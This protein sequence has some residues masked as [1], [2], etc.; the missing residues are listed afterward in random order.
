MLCIVIFKSRGWPKVMYMFPSLFVILTLCIKKLIYVYLT[1]WGLGSGG[2]GGGGTG[3][4]T[5]LYR[6]YR[7][8][9]CQ[10]V[11]FLSCF[12]QKEGI[13]NFQTFR[14]EWLKLF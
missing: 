5:P 8:V 6:L 13:N 11:W 14:P 3:G 1:P 10:R 12:G 9:K 2:G 7:Y 4:D